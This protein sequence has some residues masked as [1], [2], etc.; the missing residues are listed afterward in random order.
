[1]ANSWPS[2]HQPQ[3]SNMPF[4]YSDAESPDTELIPDGE[5]AVA[6]M[7]IK[8]GSA[9]EDGMATRS[10]GGDSE[11]LSAEFTLLDGKHARAKFWQV[12][13]TSGETDGQKQMVD[14]GRAILKAM[15]DSAYGIDP[16]DKSPEARARPQS[17]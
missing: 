1:L 5:V 16:A 3:E 6:Q 2:S 13:L 15:L 9:G 7:R 10:K 8:A 17:P 12:L 14:K 4:D 11:Y